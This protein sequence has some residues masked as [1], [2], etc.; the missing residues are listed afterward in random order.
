[1]I[2]IDQNLIFKMTNKV[3]N[4][5]QTNLRKLL[6]NQRLA[7]ADRDAVR[8][9]ISKLQT[10]QKVNGGTSK[11]PKPIDPVNKVKKKVVDSTSSRKL[12]LVTQGSKF[13]EMML[14]LLLS[15]LETPAIT[16]DVYTR[17]ISS[18]EATYLHEI[19][20]H[21]ITHGTKLFKE[22]CVYLTLLSENRNPEP[23]PLVA[24]DKGTGIISKMTGL[25]PLIELI[26]RRE[27]GWKKAYQAFLTI[28]AFPRL[29]EVIPS[30]DIST[31]E[32]RHEDIVAQNLLRI[33][34]DFKLFLSE[35]KLEAWSPKQRPYVVAPRGRMTKGPNGE[36][37]L[38][39]S[40]E[41]A[42]ALLENKQLS[43]AFKSFCSLVGREDFLAYVEK[44]ATTG[45]QDATRLGKI[46]LVPDSLNKHRLV[47]MVDY[48]TNLLLSPLEEITRDI[49]RV[50]FSRTD[51]LR[52]HG[53]GAMKALQNKGPSW[54]LDLKAFTDRFPVELQQL[55]VE[56]VLGR[57]LGQH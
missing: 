1:M 18:V 9:A 10:K 17:A 49:L 48:W 53:L 22:Y 14:V 24:T 54:S 46:S 50:R 51:F 35:Y 33:S 31:V 47:A 36:V 37:T 21:G 23:L 52:N 15:I 13:L 39:S 30:L 20:H 55:V 4:Q 3:N 19:K 16:R 7:Q 11:A 27:E 8:L 12:P 6:N 44:V 57:N 25:T 26:R 38:G 29:S 41:E 42:R 40:C 45:T 2:A 34:A 56:R 32:S 43:K 28:L 5:L